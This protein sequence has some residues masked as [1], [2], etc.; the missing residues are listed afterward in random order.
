M[1]KIIAVKYANVKIFPTRLDCL[2]DRKVSKRKVLLEE[3]PEEAAEDLQ[4]RRRRVEGIFASSKLISTSVRVEVGVG[5]RE[6]LLA[7]RELNLNSR[8]T[9]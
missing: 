1:S 8:Y 2:K 3:E 4:K 7:D 9:K 6:K 5:I